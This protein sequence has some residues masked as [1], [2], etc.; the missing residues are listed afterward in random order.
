[1]PSM[2]PMMSPILR[3][4]SRISNMV[5]AEALTISPPR[6]AISEAD[7]PRWLARL[8]LSVFC[9]AVAVN[10]SMLAAVSSR[11]E[12]C[13]SVRTDRSLFPAEISL[14]A[15]EII[16]TASTTLPISTCR[17]A[18]VVLRPSAVSPNSPG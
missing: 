2:T 12:A 17:L 11:L 16:S 13:C 7:W 14:A 5:A 18:T 4:L 10:C 15:V 8:A 9:W 1:M 6:S 3:E